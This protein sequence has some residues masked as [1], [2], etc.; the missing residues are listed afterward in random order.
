M[1]R[2]CICSSRLRTLAL[3]AAASALS[4]AAHAQPEPPMPALA[5]PISVYNNWSSYDELSDN[6]PLTETMAMRELD[7]L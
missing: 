5:T 7:E 2:Q 3:F 6:I 1:I 4:A